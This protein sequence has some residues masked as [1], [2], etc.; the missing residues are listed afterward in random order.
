[1]ARVHWRVGPLHVARGD[2]VGDGVPE[3]VL[4][5]A[6]RGDV[7]DDLADDDGELGLVVRRARVRRQDDR[8]VRADDGRVRLEE[9]Q[10]RGRDLVAQLGGVVGVV[11]ADAD[12]LG[13]RDH[14]CEQADGCR[15]RAAS[16]R[17]SAGPACR[18]GSPVMH[19]EAPR[20]RGTVDEGVPGVSPGGEPAMRMAAQSLGAGEDLAVQHGEPAVGRASPTAATPSARC[21]RAT[22]S[23]RPCATACAAKFDSVQRSAHRPDHQTRS[24]G[25]A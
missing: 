8:V 3:H 1:M 21:S 19:H 18:C 24:S 9:Q 6:V 15:R 25:V 2:V 7:L 20:S 23:A 16:P 14:R 4:Q 17:P 5:R 22:S 12:D 10:R 13:A 11:A